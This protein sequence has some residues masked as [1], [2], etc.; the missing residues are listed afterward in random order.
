MKSLFIII[1]KINAR[2]ILSAT[3]I[4]I[5]HSLKLVCASKGNVYVWIDVSGKLML[6]SPSLYECGEQSLSIFYMQPRIF[7]PKPPLKLTSFIGS[8]S[9]D[10]ISRWA[11]LI[12]P[13]CTEFIGKIA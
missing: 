11:P 8:C 13:F 3:Y 9:M 4:L 2:P 5:S 7:A 1:L 10:E 12:Y 6:N